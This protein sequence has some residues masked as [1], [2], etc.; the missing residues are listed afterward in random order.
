MLL[1]ARERGSQCEVLEGQTIGVKA[2][3]ARERDI[4]RMLPAV[5]GEGKQL[6]N[7]GT[8][9]LKSLAQ[10]CASP[11]FGQKRRVAEQLFGATNPSDGAVHLTCGLKESAE[12]ILFIGVLQLTLR[13][14]LTSRV[15]DR[16]VSRAYHMQNDRIVGLVQMMLMPHPIARRDMKFY[17]ANPFA[18]SNADTRMRIVGSGIAV[19]FA[20]REDFDRLSVRRLL[21]KSRPKAM[22]PNVM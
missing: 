12:V 22:F 21:R 3:I 14:L 4:E 18:G 20:N 8:F 7:R 13:N 5:L 1:Q 15:I 16:L 17:I 2:E 11:A 9:A 6:F 10:E 19:M